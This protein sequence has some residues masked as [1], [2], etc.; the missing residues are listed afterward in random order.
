MLIL[1]FFLLPCRGEEVSKEL[2]TESYKVIEDSLNSKNSVAV[3][4][5]AEKIC[6]LGSTGKPFVDNI[7]QALN[8]FYEKNDSKVVFKLVLALSAIGP[9][10]SKAIPRLESLLAEKFEER[11]VTTALIKIGSCT[12]ELS[13][14]TNFFKEPIISFFTKNS[15][16]RDF[17]TMTNP[18]SWIRKNSA[19][20]LSCVLTNSPLQ[21]ELKNPTNL[22]E[23]FSLNFWWKASNLSPNR[24]VNL[25]STDLV[26][27]KLSKTEYAHKTNLGISFELPSVEKNNTKIEDKKRDLFKPKIATMGSFG[28]YALL[29]ENQWNNLILTRNGSQ[30]SIKIYLNGDRVVASDDFTVWSGVN[31]NLTICF[32]ET[33]LKKVELGGK[34]FDDHLKFDSKGQLEF[35]TIEF[36]D[37]SLSE[38]AAKSKF[39]TQKSTYF[40]D[41]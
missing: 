11:F 32:P 28:K 34:P 21:I 23:N 15:L 14:C 10:A 27:F 16:K 29:S 31:S 17:F 37:C 41:K 30:H 19:G 18:E 13:D 24:A 8:Y 22:G 20:F 9:N 38:S 25:L 26:K 3:N 4:W 7:L 6:K 1:L 36:F 12:T 2:D 5:A 35:S 40:S 39:A 33:V